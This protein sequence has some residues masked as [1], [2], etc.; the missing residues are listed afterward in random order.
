MPPIPLILIAAGV[1]VAAITYLKEK[2]HD[3]KGNESGGNKRGDH[4]SGESSSD[5]DQSGGPG[6]TPDPLQ[7]KGT[8]DEISSDRSGIRS[9]RTNQSGDDLRSES[10]PTTEVDAGEAGKQRVNDPV[11]EAVDQA[12][13]EHTQKET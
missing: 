1:A 7:Q 11:D 4:R 9:I 3:G 10:E 13:T 2:D 8:Q 12:I 6:L 5:S